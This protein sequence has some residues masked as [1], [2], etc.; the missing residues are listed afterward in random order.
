[1]WQTLDLV[2]VGREGVLLLVSYHRLL[3]SQDYMSVFPKMDMK[4]IMG[5]TLRRKEY[6]LTAMTS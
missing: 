5:L 3:M 1:M 2:Q 4:L 6:S